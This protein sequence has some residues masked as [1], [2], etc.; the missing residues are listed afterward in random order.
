MGRC[1]RARGGVAL[2]RAQLQHCPAT[3]VA[4]I[5]VQSAVQAP[6]AVAEIPGSAF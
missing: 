3:L 4:V 1:C 6:V 5:L 2:W